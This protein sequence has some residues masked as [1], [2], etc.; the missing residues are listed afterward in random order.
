[1]TKVE[2]ALKNGIPLEDVIKDADM[3]TVIAARYAAVHGAAAISPA[4][5]GSLQVASL[6]SNAAKKLVDSLPNV[7]LRQ[8][9]ENASKDPEMMALLLEKGRTAKQKG[10][11]FNKFLDKLG[12]M[13]VSVGKSAVTPALNYISPEEPQTLRMSQRRSNTGLILGVAHT[14][15]PSHRWI[16]RDQWTWSVIDSC[17]E[18]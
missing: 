18:T 7:T 9:L 12:A 3:L 11:I 5:P 13:G 2:T 4:G 1:M 8:V 14:S 6:L 16:M 17:G 15:P 10:D